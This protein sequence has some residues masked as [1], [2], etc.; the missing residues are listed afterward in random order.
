MP[1]AAAETKAA[2]PQNLRLAVAPK[3]GPVGTTFTVKSIDSCPTLNGLASQFADVAITFFTDSDVV[4][5]LD[6]KAA[7]AAD[8]SWS[9]KMPVPASQTGPAHVSASCARAG[10]EVRAR[11]PELQFEVTTRGAGFWLLSATPLSAACFCRITTNVLAAGDA[12]DY[13]PRPALTGPPLVGIA[14]NP[15]TG[16]GYWLAQSDGGVFAT[17]DARFFGSTGGLR[18]ARPV[19]GIAATPSGHGYWLVASDGGVFA[20]GDARFFGSTGG[21]RLARP[22]VGIATTP[23]GRGYW[24]AASDGGVFAFGDARFFG[25]AV[26]PGPVVPSVAGIAPTPSGHG[27]WLATSTGAVF[28]F[29]DTPA[30]AACV[31]GC[32]TNAVV[33]IARTP[34]TTARA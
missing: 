28:A 2:P 21:L 26:P 27:Y 30:I 19:V 23:S 14:P 3:R 18:L 34:V 31:E 10:V 11:Y 29:G 6:L 17:G 8:G 33:A 22:V 32:G 4:Q 15:T 20:F 5:V 12:N 9:A 7:V 16:T 1:S 25:S 13:G 24:L